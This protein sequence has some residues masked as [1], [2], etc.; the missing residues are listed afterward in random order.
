M[1]PCIA[2]SS[3]RPFRERGRRVEGSG[4][5]ACPGPVG[6]NKRLRAGPAGFRLLVT[7]F[8]RETIGQPFPGEAAPGIDTK[9]PAEHGAR[10]GGLSRL[11]EDLT[12]SQDCRQMPGI[13]VENL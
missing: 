4:G 10:L 5:V 8:P 2:M 1:G 3:V 11:L 6:R 7:A 12:H 9:R 13:V